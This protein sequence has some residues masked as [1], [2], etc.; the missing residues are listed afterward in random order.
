[1]AS[2]PDRA[3]LGDASGRSSTISCATL[4]SDS[5]QKVG[6]RR[7]ASR[8][9]LLAR[10]PLAEREQGITIDVA[11]RYFDTETRRFVVIDSPGHEQYT[12]NMASGASHADVAIM[13]VTR[14]T[15]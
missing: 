13:L 14:A 5:S 1:M 7:R 10:R 8:L 15:A 4:E 6:D 2:D 11:W 9:A 3:S 12:R